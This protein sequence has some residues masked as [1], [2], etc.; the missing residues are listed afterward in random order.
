MGT[1]IALPPAATTGKNEECIP[2]EREDK[3]N[4]DKGPITQTLRI[5]GGQYRG[6]INRA[7]E[8]LHTL[9]KVLRTWEHTNLP[10][11]LF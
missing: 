7:A 4:P 5:F 3:R 10:N 6:R 11:L 9:P 2:P 1:L 8:K